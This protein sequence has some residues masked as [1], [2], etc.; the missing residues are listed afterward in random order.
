M[1]VFF[2]S[3]DFTVFIDGMGI[4]IKSEFLH[5]ICQPTGLLRRFFF[6][7]L[8]G[9]LD[10]LE[11]DSILLIGNLYLAFGFLVIIVVIV[12]MWILLGNIM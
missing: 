10:P 12:L 2:E 6:I 8:L 3:D 4:L 9:L 1:S 5:H 7:N 11:L